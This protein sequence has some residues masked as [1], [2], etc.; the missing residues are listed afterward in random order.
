[1]EMM[2]ALVPGPSGGNWFWSGVG[3]SRMRG[4]TAT[5][6]PVSTCK[7]G[8]LELMTMNDAHQ[9]ELG[10]TRTASFQVIFVLTAGKEESAAIIGSL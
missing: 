2:I 6:M 1:M 4:R 5:K 7:N 3:S 10:M 9:H 8:G